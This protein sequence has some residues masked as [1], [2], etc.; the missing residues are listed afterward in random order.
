[1]AEFLQPAHTR[2]ASE[3][4]PQ[5][6][7]LIHGL[8]FVVFRYQV[9]R[10]FEFISDA[11]ERVT[12]Y[13][14]NEFYEDIDL[15]T[16]LVHP[17]D[18]PI[19]TDLVEL[20]ASTPT[21]L[22]WMHK[23]GSPRW[24]E[25]VAFPHKNEAGE[26]DGFEGSAR[27]ITVRVRA[28][29][30]VEEG[31]N[32]LRAVLSAASDPVFIT[33]PAGVLI[34]CNDAFAAIYD[35]STEKIVGTSV[36]DHWEPGLKERRLVEIE[37]ALR[38]RE[39]VR[40]DDQTARGRYFDVV[41]E[42]ILNDLGNVNQLAFFARD[43]TAR[44]QAEEALRS[45][46]ER[47]R[48]LY[49][50]NATMY[51]TVDPDG[52]VCS[53]NQFG[54]EQLGYTPDELVGQPVVGVFHE[55]DRR[56]VERQLKACVAN[57]G[58]VA[59][60]EFRKIRKDGQVRWV[61]EAA[62]ATRDTN[63][64]AIVLIVCEDVTEWRRMEEEL[65]AAREDIESKVEETLEETNPYDLTFRQLTVLHLVAQGKSDREI[66]LALGIS[67]LTVNTHVSRAL[68]KMGASSR[69]EAGVRALREGLIR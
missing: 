47:Y 14:P 55:D 2:D 56:E 17:E 25:V 34:A 37:K 7:R 20:R 31:A 10:G 15:A 11:V 62:R 51:F 68:K 28:E 9:D 44:K 57:P 24:V 5:F 60:W 1:M 43:I 69:T 32:M 64:N 6:E 42:P 49:Q 19:L 16:K 65:Q 30:R 50:D 66:G 22:R 26:I 36:Y 12:G 39:R 45:N 52:T 46:E 67:P 23:D 53:V 13:T 61:R 59:N 33:D 48:I 27:D 58:E 21:R 38:T 8:P 4:D 54:A 18:A 35:T 63:G 40:F 3:A 41:I 29:R